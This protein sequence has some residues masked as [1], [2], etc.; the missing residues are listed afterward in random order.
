MT[1]GTGT[2]ST[3]Q[4]MKNQIGYKTFDL[5]CDVNRELRFNNEEGDKPIQNVV[6]LGIFRVRQVPVVN[7]NIIDADT[8][9]RAR[10]TD[11]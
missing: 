10:W 3:T 8:V 7:Q 2:G 4:E 1:D 9:Y 5:Y 11:C 6:L